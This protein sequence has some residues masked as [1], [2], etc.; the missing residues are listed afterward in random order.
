MA[1]QDISEIRLLIEHEGQLRRLCKLAFS[2]SDAS[3]Y[4]FPYARTGS[5]FFGSR[6]MPERHFKDSFPFKQQLSSDQVPKISIHESGQVHVTSK[7]IRA[8]PLQIPPLS[9]LRGEHIATVS[10]DE[11]SV[12]AEF[13]G[14][15][16]LRGRRIDHVI[17]V[18]ENVKSGR[19]AVYVAG[20]RAAFQAPNCPLVV[21]VKRPTLA[22]PIYVGLKPISQNPIGHPAGEGVIAIAGWDPTGQFQEGADYLFIRGI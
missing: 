6:S 22:N 3:I 5:F 9:S 7:G 13:R 4:V 10:A 8:G 15:P 21:T 14:S 19:I 16:K 20:D 2:K 12:L 17:S 18:S 1:G 11:F